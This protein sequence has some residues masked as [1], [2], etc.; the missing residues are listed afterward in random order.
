MTPSQDAPLDYYEVL[1]LSPNADQDTIQ[2]VYRL[3]AQRYHPDNQQS[4]DAA[5]FRA[6]TEA[7]TVL[8]DP[9][10]RAEYDV[11]HQ[12]AAQSR[13][14]LVDTGT[15]AA[16]DFETEQVTRLTFLEVLYTR[17]RVEPYAPSISV[18][19]MEQLIGQPREHLEFTVWFLVQKGF[20]TRGDS[21][22]LT[23][24]AAGVEYLEQN[25]QAAALRKRLPAASGA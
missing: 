7:H 8:S 6:I 2:R 23:I 15:R 14:R 1:Q 21:S 25:Y 24:T 19:D 5:K 22:E 17:R 10:K 16:S 4:G 18:L 13:W 20:I 3:F 12:Q 11:K 9:V